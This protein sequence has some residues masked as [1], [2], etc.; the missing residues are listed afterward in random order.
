MYS[1]KTNQIKKGLLKKYGRACKEFATMTMLSV[2]E[3]YD[4]GH[5]LKKL[6]RLENKLA[7]EQMRQWSF[8]EDY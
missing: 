7:K 4:N 5:N 1:D 2:P 8:S 3:L 6:K